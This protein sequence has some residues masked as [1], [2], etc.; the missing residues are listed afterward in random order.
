MV[1][2]A[3]RSVLVAVLPA[4]G[5]VSPTLAVVEGLLLD[6]DSVHVLTGRKYAARFTEIGAD[7]T[8]LDAPGDFDDDDLD[9]SFPGR[10]GLSGLQLARHDLSEAFVRPMPSR[11]ASLQKAMQVSSPDVVLVDPF[12]LAG[13]PLVPTRDATRRPRVLVLGLLP[14]M[15]PPLAPPGLGWTLR[16]HATRTGMQLALRPVDR[17]ARR[18]TEQLTGQSLPVWFTEWTALSDGILQLTCP[19][20]EYPRPAAPCPIHFVGPPSTSTAA[21]I[22]L[23]AWWDELESARSVI[24]VTQG[25]IANADPSQVIMPTLEALAD[26]EH[27]VVVTTGGTPLPAPAPVNV[28]V[29][30]LLPYDLLLP[31]THVM[32]TNGGYGGVNF[33]LR[34]G[35]PL[36]VVGASE[37]KRAIAQRIQW[38]GAGLGIPKTSARPGRIARA[39]DRVGTDLTYRRA[40][41]KLAA[42]IASIDTRRA[43]R[44][45]IDTTLTKP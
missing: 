32:V 33:A 12:F 24:H 21:Q 5:H 18:L 27:L 6:G 41:Q 14:L 34:H 30:D 42:Q 35:V 13:I 3:P 19:G 40:A 38:S 4:R 10:E 31:R 29:A 39:V 28:R 20:F 16:E 9:G 37:D 23:P 17:L 2:A 22:P 8:A 11:W 45:A 36:V 26:T 1:S 7:V 25:T 43:I 44:H 15:L